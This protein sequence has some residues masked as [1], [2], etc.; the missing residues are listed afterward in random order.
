M[1]ERKSRT[2]KQYL[3]KDMLGMLGL[4]IEGV[5]KRKIHDGG[6]SGSFHCRFN[7]EKAFHGLSCDT[8][9]QQGHGIPL[10]IH[11]EAPT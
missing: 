4:P 7:R 11:T 1:E 5:S 2:E 10:H 6:N 8:I 9:R 3:V